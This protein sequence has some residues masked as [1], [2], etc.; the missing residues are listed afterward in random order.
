M[1]SEPDGVRIDA[2]DFELFELPLR[3]VQDRAVIDARWKTLQLQVHPDRFVSRGDAA[4]RLALQSAIR[5]NEAY[6]RL[7][8]P[9]AR[10]AYLCGLHGQAPGLG[11]PDGVAPEVLVQ[12][13]AW[14][15]TLERATTLADV[16]GLSSEVDARRREGHARLPALLD[17]QRD[18]P[19]AGA[20]IAALMFIERLALDIER[21][22]DA[23]NESPSR[24]IS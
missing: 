1:T 20:Q 15:E 18:W 19:A 8:N 13:M 6:Q 5:V 12:Q 4:Q 17:E 16:D 23:L 21:H 2:S 11:T 10:A 22:R 3:F 24:G 7:K 9:L 14:R